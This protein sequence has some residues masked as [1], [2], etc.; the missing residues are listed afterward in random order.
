MDAID[1][2]SDIDVDDVAVANRRV[3]RDAVADHLVE[4]GA[5][6]LREGPVAQRAGI[7]TMITEEIVADAIQLV[8]GHAGG[9]MPADLHQGLGRDP[10]GYPHALDRLG[11]LDIPLSATRR[12]PA[13]VFGPGNAGRDIAR[14]GKP[15]RLEGCS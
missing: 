13:D 2:G 1:I 15:T 11:V 12:T 6:R 3:V 10:P 8:G 4:R 9:H 14:W 7:G 5:Q